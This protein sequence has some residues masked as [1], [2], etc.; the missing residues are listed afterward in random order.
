MTTS[1]YEKH[2][3]EL[4]ESFGVEFRAVLIGDDCPEFCE[5]AQND[6]DMDKL[7]VFPRRTHIHGKHYRCTFSAKGRGHFTVDFWN[8]Y[9]DAE[10][11]AFHHGK[12]E[13][14]NRDNVYWDKHR[15]TKF[16]GLIRKPLQVP[17]PYDVLACITKNDPG[18]FADFCS[19]FGYDEDSRRAETIYNA[20]VKEWR[21][22]EKF[23]TAEER[24]K[25]QEVA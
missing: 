22:V 18:T 23:F 3:N 13:I 17:T 25:L 6:R 12:G 7:N 19:E 11:N 24:E 4:L 20:V 1:T 5:D 14:Q 9:H 21:K 16:P 15:G 10:S 2:A 8:S